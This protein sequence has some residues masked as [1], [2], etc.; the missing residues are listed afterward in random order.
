MKMCS[1]YEA[2]NFRYSL[3]LKSC[4]HDY[5]SHDFV[6]ITDLEPEGC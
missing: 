2:I 6:R 1:G 3:L 4:K 5:V